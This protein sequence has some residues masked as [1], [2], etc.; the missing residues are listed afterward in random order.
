MSQLDNVD[1]FLI[2]VLYRAVLEERRKTTEKRRQKYFH[3]CIF[4]T[5]LT[6]NLGENI[7]S[8]A[9]MTR[10][11]LPALMLAFSLAAPHDTAAQTTDLAVTLDG[12]LPPGG[13]TGRETDFGRM[14]PR[15]PPFQPN[16]TLL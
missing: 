8:S 2:L 6:Y 14:F 7:M 13:A 12:Y 3:P 16:E 15:L 11:L 10:R 4:T 1:Y 5:D 9:S